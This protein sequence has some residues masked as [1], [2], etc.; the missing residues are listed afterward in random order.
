MTHRATRRRPDS[1]TFVACVPT[2]LAMNR[3]RFVMSPGEILVVVR[4]QRQSFKGASEECIG[5]SWC[6]P[7]R[8]ARGRVGRVDRP[9]TATGLVEALPD[10]PRPLLAACGA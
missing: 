3:Q 9:G 6:R 1:P 4:S 2:F 5:A 10:G 8:Q 7:V